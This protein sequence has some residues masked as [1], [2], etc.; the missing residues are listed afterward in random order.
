MLRNMLNGIR[1]A[2]LA[3]CGAF[4]ACA[5]V[6]LGPE[7]ATEE[8]AFFS[9]DTRLSYALDI[10]VDR[11]PPYPTVVFGHDSGP[12]TKNEN[13][14]WAR[15][16]VENGFAVFRFDK[17]GVGDSEGVYERGSVDVHLL[18]GDLVAA[19]E[20]VSGDDRIDRTKIGLMGSSQAGWILPIV[21]T[22][23]PDI[24]FAML[25]S[26]PAVTVAQ[27]NFWAARAEDGD[28]TIDD[29]AVMLED[30][31][32]PAVG[33]FD[34]RPFIEAMTMP[35]L[36][37]LGEQDRIIPGRESARIVEEISDELGSPF[38]VVLYPGTSHGLRDSRTGARID[39]WSDLLPWLGRVSACSD[40]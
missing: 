35:S 7:V 27:H 21:A 9:G 14:D 2:S 40:C 30:F 36:W 4:A 22:T 28:L 17:R 12:N 19:V 1:I 31:D 23:S 29:L 25:L 11:A 18:A 34:P 24:A 8:G 38:T 20:F 15:R 32:P 10:P 5:S 39:F 3:A 16:L 37:L 26:A 33:D 6:P 13:K